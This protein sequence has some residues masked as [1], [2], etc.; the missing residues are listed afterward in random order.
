M[1]N[2]EDVPPCRPGAGI[3]SAAL[4]A[5]LRER[6]EQA[7]TD[8]ER[9]YCLLTLGRLREQA[10]DWPGAAKWYARAFWMQP[11]T[12][13]TWY[14]LHNN[15]GYCLNH[16]GEHQRAEAYCRRAIEI[17]PM[18][19]NA[20]KNLGIALEG[21]GR[22]AD[23]A[24]AWIEAATLCPA[25]GRAL[26]L[27]RKLVAEQPDLG[28]GLALGN[29]VPAADTE[30]AAAEAAPDKESPRRARRPSGNTAAPGNPKTCT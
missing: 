15:L 28:L 20:W 17:D 4:E 24:A 9:A 11:G 3:D 14:F 21:L 25:D 18:R 26:R 5:R 13:E 30:P 23:A 6:V 10:S 1:V 2:S 27:L 16:L 22:H 12:D 19:H 8:D 7:E 29:P